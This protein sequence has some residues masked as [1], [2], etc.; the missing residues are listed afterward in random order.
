MNRQRALAVTAAGAIATALSL[1]AGA[2]PA[3][4]EI[5]DAKAAE[6]R[7]DLTGNVSQGVI[8]GLQNTFGLTEAE[9]YDRLAVEDVAAD[10]LAEVPADLDES[11]A[12]LWVSE[13]ADEVFVATT[14]A[15]D[16]TG[17]RA[18]GATPVLVEHDLAT[19]EDAA[20]ALTAIEID[21][22]YGNYVDVVANTLVVEAADAATA[23][24]VIEAAG[25][26]PAL[27]TVDAGAEAPETYFV[28]GGDAY[29]I[30]N[31]WRCSVGFAVRQGS[32]PG[33]VTAGHCGA[34]GDSV[35]G[36]EAAPGT[37]RNSVFPSADRAWVAVGT[38]EVLYDDVNMYSGTRD[39]AN[40]TVAAVGSSI[41]RSGSTTGWHCGTVQAF[42]QTV[43]YAE[44]AV[45]GMTRT[46]VCAEP[47]DS[48]GSF[49]SGNSAQGMTSGGSGNCSSGGT[50]Y[51]QPIGP[52]LSA[53]GLTLVTT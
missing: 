40:A 19:L 13:D 44:G 29:N 37:F 27:A 2:A 34:A 18:E 49:I 30:E 43:R 1:A 4:A 3:S 33:F 21:G 11:Y 45:Y 50:T 48:G 25:I 23:A 42:N 41:C 10:L 39:V 8:D 35:T 26:D 12:G 53:W 15:A 46:N 47:G 20:S 36:G 51:F 16:T 32:T 31:S 38:G 28:R 52:A 14:D 22:Y 9:A 6:A 17:L 24:D 5:L 7:A